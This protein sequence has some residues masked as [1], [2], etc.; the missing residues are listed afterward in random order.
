MSDCVTVLRVWMICFA[1][2]RR[3]KTLLS[4]MFATVCVRECAC[5][6]AGVCVC[7]IGY[8]DNKCTKQQAYLLKAFVRLTKCVIVR[9]QRC[10]YVTGA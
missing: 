5:V 9:R 1:P 7:F 2:R 10:V 8:Y 6:C 3:H 4:H